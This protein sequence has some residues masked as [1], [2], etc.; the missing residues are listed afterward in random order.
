MTGP[1]FK[2]YSRHFAANPYPTYAHLRDK[3]PIFYSEEYE[4]TFFSRYRDIAALLEDERLGRTMEHVLTRQELD[5][6]RRAEG[7]ER[8]PNYSRYVRVN[9]LE[10]AGSHHDRLRR[11]LKKAFNAVRI[12]KLRSR[13][14]E[15]TD[16]LIQDL[17]SRGQMEF[18]ADLA[19]PL[20]VFMISELLGWPLE[21][22]H[23]LRPWSAA[24][25]KLYEKD[26][27]EADELEAEAA[28][29]EFATILRELIDLRRAEPTDDLI[30][31]LAH[32]ELEG[33]RLSDD[34]MIASCMLFL[35]AGHEATVNAAGNGMLA[36]L[37]HPDQRAQLANNPSLIGSA[38]DEMFR[39][40][41]PLHFFHRYVLKDLE[42]EGHPCLK[43]DTVG[44]LYGAAN[45]DPEAFP[46]PDRFDITRNPNRHLAF[47]RGVHFCMG[48]PLARLE[49]EILFNTL[50]ERIPAIRLDEPEPEFN[51]GL[52]FRG[53]KR[54]RL[55]W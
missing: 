18:L 20:P 39:F 35:N 55:S 29:T 8:L 53:L 28:A 23:R 51:T 38:L 7:W 14:Q 32:V 5:A 49:L 52:V 22:R 36:L 4:L 21:E 15:L 11:L 26:H 17:L 3:H 10:T 40:D 9:L 37:S 2:P 6:K 12:R 30:S 50:L 45:R 24:I 19:V 46:A 43:G 54:L 41:P 48:A 31:T 44:F 25:V 13:I 27:T 16:Q 33:E 47:G 34:E 42:Y 1:N